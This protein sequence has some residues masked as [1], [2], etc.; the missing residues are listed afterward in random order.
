V[1]ISYGSSTGQTGPTGATGASGPTGPEGAT[2]ATGP[3]GPEGKQGPTGPEGKEGT[4]GASGPTGPAG[5]TGA[6][7][8]TGPEGKQGPTG[9]EGKEGTQGPTGPEGKEGKQGEPG[10]T[11]PEG[12]EGKT[13]ATGAAGPNTLG[14]AVARFASKDNVDNGECLGVRDNFGHNHCP[15]RS[16]TREFE[17]WAEGPVPAAGGSVSNLWAEASTPVPAGKST[18]VDVIDTTAPSGTPSVVLKCEVTTGNTTCENTTAA[19]IAQGHYMLVR[20]N[21]TAPP[22]TWRVTFR[23]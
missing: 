19:P 6:T 18:T 9:P 3:T 14:G 4:Q 23:Y 8:P 16:T 12:K 11:G 7:G 1:Q 2:G 22:A 10:A 21:T 20:I 15:P 5:A 13:G 17:K